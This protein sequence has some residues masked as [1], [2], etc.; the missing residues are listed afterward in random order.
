MHL[1]FNYM[2]KT[3]KM[4]SAAPTSRLQFPEQTLL[5][6]ATKSQTIDVHI[7]PSVVIKKRV[8]GRVRGR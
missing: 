5:N 3:A 7:S 4:T 2:Q 8:G 6:G 1:P